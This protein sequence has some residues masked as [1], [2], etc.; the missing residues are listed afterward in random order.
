MLKPDLMLDKAV[1]IATQVE[2][3]VQQA[4]TIAADDSVS[5]QADVRSHL[6]RKTNNTLPQI[7][8]QVPSLHPPATASGVDLTNI[9][10][11]FPNTLQ[12]RKH[13]SPVI[14]S[15]ILL[16]FANQLKSPVW[17]RYSYPN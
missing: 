14:K 6:K 8:L 11:I 10:L 16:V 17:V 5:I 4:K 9:W 1:T 3:A 13:A 15:D 12:P 7:S 2:C